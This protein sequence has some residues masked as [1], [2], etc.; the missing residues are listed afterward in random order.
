[1]KNIEDLDKQA[2]RL[3]AISACKLLR[4]ISIVSLCIDAVLI[5]LVVLGTSFISVEASFIIFLFGLVIFFIACIF[6][7]FT[8]VYTKKY[9]V[10]L[11]ANIIPKLNSI[12]VFMVLSIIGLVLSTLKRSLL[13]IIV[14]AVIIYSWYDLIACIKK[15]NSKND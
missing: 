6:N 8:I 5:F 3:R 11:K 14:Y 2:I 1:M 13:N 7:I 9:I 15:L 4:I 10:E 12:Y